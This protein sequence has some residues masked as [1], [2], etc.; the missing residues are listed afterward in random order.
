MNTSTHTR[1]VILAAAGAVLALGISAGIPVSAAAATPVDLTVGGGLLA[2]SIQAGGTFTVSL[3]TPSTTGVKFKIDGTYLGEDKTVPYSWPVSA[4]EGT[5]TIEA[6]WEG[7]ETRSSFSVSSGAPVAAPAPAPA[8]AP[9]TTPAPTTGASVVSV[10]TSAQ[11][12]AALSSA[13][14]GQT[15]A[16]ASGT[17]TGKFVAGSSGTSDKPITLTGPRTAVLTTGSITSGYA[18]HLTG[19]H[20]KVTGLTVKTA[21]K[22]IVLDGSRFTT[23]SHVDVGDIGAEAVHFRTGS[24]DG[25]I[26]NSIIHDT[27]LDDPKFGEGVYIGSAKSNWPSIMGST[28]TPDR[29][30]RVTVRGNDIRNTTAE[31]VDVKEGTTGGSITGNTFTASG[32]SGSNSAD[33]WIDVKGNG[34]RVTG[35]TGTTTLLDAI[36]VHTVLAGWGNSNTF[37][38]NTVIGGVPGYAV[39]VQSSAIG[40]TV[41]CETSLATKGLTNIRCS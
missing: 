12:K 4:D 38:G 30:D 34:Y 22:G 29:S 2:S 31:G 35:N 28:T 39:W 13:Q 9:T 37:S 24:S 32:V 25:V 15:I 5:H 36:Q 1:E 6:R 33:S 11:L 17:Y 20:W 19:S 21:A 26:E 7:G 18:L 27:G 14:P 10:S 41:A 40:N 23:I 3:A 8:P 16:L